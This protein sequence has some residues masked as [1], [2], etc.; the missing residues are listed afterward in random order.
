MFILLFLFW[1]I[2]K[3]RGNLRIFKFLLSLFRFG[4]SCS[5]LNDRLIGLKM[6]K[7]WSVLTKKS[8]QVLLVLVDQFLWFLL[9]ESLYIIKIQILVI[10]RSFLDF[11]FLFVKILTL[12]TFFNRDRVFLLLLIFYLWFL[13]NVRFFRLK[14]RF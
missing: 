5:C 12:M 8:F 11:D 4:K 9:F 7:R 13:V 14:L 3:F 1:I 10:Y 6:W 2:Q